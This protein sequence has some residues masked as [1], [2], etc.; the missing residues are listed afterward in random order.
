VEKVGNRYVLSYNSKGGI[1]N[2]NNETDKSS[3]SSSDPIDMVVNLT[4]HPIEIKKLLNLLK[5]E[6]P[7]V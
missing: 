7:Q 5:E 1:Y 6:Y 3:I 2:N 4:R